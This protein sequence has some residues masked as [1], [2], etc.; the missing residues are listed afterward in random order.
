MSQ[1]MKILHVST[2]NEACG[3]GRFQERSVLALNQYT[4]SH[5]EFYPTSPNVIKNMPENDRKLEIAQLVKSAQS[6][7]VVHMQ[8]EFGFYY[9]AG[10]GFDEIVT[11]LK[12]ANI[13][14]VVTLHTAPGLL[15]QPQ[16][17]GSKSLRGVV[18]MSIRKLKNK[19]TLQQRIRPLAKAD[20][21]LTF[22]EF[23]QKQ[24]TDMASVDGSRICKTMLPVPDSNGYSKNPLLR[25]KM[26]AAPKDVLLCAPGFINPYKGFDQAIKALRLLPVNVKLAIIGGVNPDSGD[27]SYVNG[28]SD[29]IVH[30]G[31]EKRVTISGFVDNDDELLKMIA[32]C[33]V[34]LYPYDPVYYKLASSDA[35]NKAICSDIPIVA[36]PTPSFVEVNSA[37]PGTLKLTD[38]PAYYDIAKKVTE[39]LQGGDVS[40]GKAM[41]QYADRYSM[42]NYAKLLLDMYQK[43]LS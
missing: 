15:L 3:I 35:L 1:A 31:L 29:L 8:H 7:D 22:N 14:V 33:D 32:S 11:A 17:L 20:Y 43:V 34:A 18:G 25:E 5:S 26:G 6:F 38:G 4:D 30:L 36:Y 9:G 10:I 21:I 12:Q 19:K 16:T 40:T 23:T 13:P 28:L 27:V 41:H 37:V 2:H 39:C 42:Q 24:L